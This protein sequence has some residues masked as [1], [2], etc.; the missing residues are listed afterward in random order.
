[1]SAWSAQVSATVLSDAQ[2]LRADQTLA[3]ARRQ[4][5]GHS[6]LDRTGLRPA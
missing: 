6:H 1:M 5:S 3:A 2:H 4:R